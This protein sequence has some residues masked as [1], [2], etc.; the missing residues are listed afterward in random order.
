MHAALRQ[1]EPTRWRFID[2]ADV[3]RAAGGLT[4][5]RLAESLATYADGERFDVRRFSLVGDAGIAEWRLTLAC[6]VLRAATEE[7]QGKTK[8]E[9]TRLDLLATAQLHGP[10]G[11][12]CRGTFSIE[13]SYDSHPNHADCVPCRWRP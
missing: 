6:S 1:A 7:A 9:S 13:V 10:G 12:L 4:S 5:G 11:S 3:V 2:T 8:S